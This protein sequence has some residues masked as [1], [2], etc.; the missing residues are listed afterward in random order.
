MSRKQF[1]ESI[2]GLVIKTS[3]NSG[4]KKRARSSET[5]KER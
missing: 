2:G 1:S 3:A 5:V 4:W